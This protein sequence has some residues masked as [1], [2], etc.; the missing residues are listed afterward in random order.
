V[1]GRG[2]GP[3]LSGNPF[4]VQDQLVAALDAASGLGRCPKARVNV[5]E[6]EQHSGVKPLMRACGQVAS[7]DSS[8]IVALLLISGANVKLRDEEEGFTALHHACSSHG[9]RLIIALLVNSGAHPVA[10]T[11]ASTAGPNTR[12]YHAVTKPLRPS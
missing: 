11:L 9:D 12:V 8:Q 2:G 10:R 4:T 3:G 7:P 6:R 1:R 5:D